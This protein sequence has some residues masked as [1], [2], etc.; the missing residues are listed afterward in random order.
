MKNNK[1]NRLWLVF[2][3]L[4]LMMFMTLSF[5]ACG[6]GGQDDPDDDNGDN[7][8]D[9]SGPLIINDELGLITVEVE[10][11]EATVFFHPE[12]WEE[13]E[14]V[15]KVNE[16]AEV[17][18]PSEGPFPVI[19][20]GKKVATAMVG[21][22]ESL[23][24]NFMTDEFLMP[25]LVM[26]M[27]DGTVEWIQLNPFIMYPG[28]SFEGTIIL[29]LL[30]DIVSLTYEDE[31]EGVGGKSI[32]ASDSQGH[33]YN[34]RLAQ[35]YVDFFGG[36]WSGTVELGQ[37]TFYVYLAFGQNGVMKMTQ[38]RAHADDWG[39]SYTGTYI[40]HLDEEA[41][42]GA[43]PGIL[44]VDLELDPSPWMGDSPD[45]A[46]S[47]KGDYFLDAAGYQGWM[48]AYHSDGDYLLTVRGQ[49][50]DF[51]SFWIEYEFGVPYGDSYILSTD[52]L[53]EE[54][55]VDYL[56]TNLGTAD[57]YVKDEGMAVLVTGEKSFVENEGLCREVWLGTDHGTQ[58]VKEILY[59]VSD[60]GNI[61]EYE[62]IIDEW[63]IMYVPD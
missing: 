39:A 50:V 12:V 10:D 19:T 5:T 63:L 47:I 59:G 13:Y 36:F 54:E 3:A 15:T 7:D 52:F 40:L 22:V 29:S 31:G 42:K 61:Y 62:P 26:A 45:I 32:F 51:I 2:F 38:S 60:F 41:S 21:Q 24:I 8:I 9:A 20:S 18:A 37:D 4:V 35:K 25:S 43:R 57:D 27:E 34:V 1:K 11:G 28:D 16:T 53:S 55:L 6:G 46:P 23:G 33:K 17:Y 30:D 14:D 48:E 56:L 49:E 44:S 58:F